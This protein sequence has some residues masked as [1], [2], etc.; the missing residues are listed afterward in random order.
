M[1]DEAGGWFVDAFVDE[2]EGFGA[3]C[4][5][6]GRVMEDAFYVVWVCAFGA[7][8]LGDCADPE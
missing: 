2:V 5:G 4:V 8:E 3:W 1:W 6:A 7:G